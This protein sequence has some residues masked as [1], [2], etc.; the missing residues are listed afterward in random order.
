MAPTAIAAIRTGLGFFLEKDIDTFS[1]PAEVAQAPR[2]L[3]PPDIGSHPDS[4]EPGA[5][6][7]SHIDLRE[8]AMTVHFATVI[9]GGGSDAS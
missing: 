4:P 9:P 1:K 5:P 3:R 2:G 6:D 7:T 8:A